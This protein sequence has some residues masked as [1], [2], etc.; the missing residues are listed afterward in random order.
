[1]SDPVTKL[2]Y[3]TALLER[4]NYSNQCHHFVAVLKW[5]FCST[6]SNFMWEDSSPFSVLLIICSSFNSDQLY[7]LAQL[8]W[9]SVCV[10]FPHVL[11]LCSVISQITMHSPMKC[12]WHPYGCLWCQDRIA[13]HILLCVKHVWF[14]GKQIPRKTSSNYFTYFLKTKGSLEQTVVYY[15]RLYIHPLKNLSLL[16]VVL[17]SGKIMTEDKSKAPEMETEV[18]K[19]Q[20]EVKTIPNEAA[21]TNGNE[22]KAWSR[23][24]EGRRDQGR[25]HDSPEETVKHHSIK[26]QKATKKRVSFFSVFY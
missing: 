13:E 2:L 5:M 18:K 17:S 1:M 10:P 9:C 8:Y 3:F 14:Q 23:P 4:M 12:L 19:A 24:R 22:S 21:Q 20:T 26:W 11:Y 7:L 6:V 15:K 25:V 16:C